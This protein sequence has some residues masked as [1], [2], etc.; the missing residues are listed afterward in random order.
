MSLVFPGREHRLP[1]FS[2]AR[3]AEMITAAAHIP[4]ERLHFAIALP[5]SRGTTF[6]FIFERILA[7]ILL[8][9]TVPL[10]ALLA[11]VIRCTS[12]GPAIYAQKRLGLRNRSFTLFKL[13]TMKHDCERLTGPCWAIPNDS[14]V[15]RV[16]RPL[17]A[18]HMDELP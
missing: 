7:A 8:A 11:L 2:R 18:T 5:T 6:K 1:V 4:R 15:T 12:R 3:P 14:R 17:R 13:R 10:L 9:I 16:G